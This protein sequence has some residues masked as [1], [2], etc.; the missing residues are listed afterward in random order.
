MGRGGGGVRT[1]QEFVLLFH[2]DKHESKCL[3]LLILLEMF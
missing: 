3:H 1:I 2:H